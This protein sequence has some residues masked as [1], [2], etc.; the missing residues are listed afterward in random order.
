MKTQKLL[1]V[2]AIVFL[3]QMSILTTRLSAA[4]IVLPL[5]KAIVNPEL[6]MALH[7]QADLKE[8]RNNQESASITI[9]VKVKDNVY[10]VYGTTEEWTRFFTNDTPPVVGVDRIIM[11]TLSNGNK[12][13]MKKL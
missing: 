13:M 2:A 10:D 11:S 6:V 3:A 8:I 7:H 5:G 9:R 12:G 1:I 4:E